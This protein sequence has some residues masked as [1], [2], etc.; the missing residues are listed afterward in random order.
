MGG[1]QYGEGPTEFILDGF[2]GFGSYDT[3]DLFYGVFLGNEYFVRPIL[4][5]F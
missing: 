3:R 5:K 1:L 4:G 2:D